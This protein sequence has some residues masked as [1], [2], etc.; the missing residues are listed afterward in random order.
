MK[1]VHLSLAFMVLLV[2]AVILSVGRAR[3]PAD[4]GAGGGAEEDWKVVHARRAGVGRE[5]LE[6][7]LAALEQAMAAKSASWSTLEAKVARGEQALAESRADLRKRIEEA[8]VEA[9]RLTHG[10]DLFAAGMDRTT[11]LFERYQELELRVNRLEGDIRWCES[12]IP[13]IREEIEATVDPD[14]KKKLED[15]LQVDVLVP[16]GE[17][18]VALEEI[19]DEW[20]TVQAARTAYYTFH[21]SRMQSWMDRMGQAE[22]RVKLLEEELADLPLALE[23]DHPEL[24]LTEA[25]AAWWKTGTSLRAQ[26]AATPAVLESS[27]ETKCVLCHFTTDEGYW[28][29]GRLA[30]SEHSRT[31]GDSTDCAG[32][33]GGDGAGTALPAA[34]AGLVPGTL[35]AAARE[36]VSGTTRLAAGEAAW[37]NHRCEACHELAGEGPRRRTGAQLDGLNG[38]ARYDWIVRWLSDPE[39]YA[40]H[41]AMPRYGLSERESQEVALFF[42]QFAHAHHHH[43]GGG[44]ASATS[45]HAVDQRPEGAAG[46][47]HADGQEHGSGPPLGATITGYDV[48]AGRSLFQSVGCLGCHALRRDSEPVGVVESLVKEERRL[49]RG[50]PP[51]RP[52]IP[53]GTV[54][55]EKVLKILKG[56]GV[57]SI[58]VFVEAPLST[59]LIDERARLAAGHPADDPVFPAGTVIDREVYDFLKADKV[60][61]VALAGRGDGF[62]PDLTFAGDKLK[63]AHLTMWIENPVIHQ[64]EA[65]MP[66][67]GLTPTESWLIATWLE[68]LHD[69]KGFVPV[70]KGIWRDLPPLAA[71]GV[72]F[73]LAAS[74]PV[75]AAGPEVTFE[76]SV[77]FEGA[78]DPMG[79]D[80]FVGLAGTIFE[81]GTVD[82]IELFPFA[83]RERNVFEFAYRFAAPGAARFRLALV[84]QPGSPP[85]VVEF[86][87][88]VAAKSASL[89]AAGQELVA[90]LSC[91]SCH[92]IP[93]VAAP[94]RRDLTAALRE[95]RARLTPEEFAAWLVERTLHHRLPGASVDSFRFDE[96]AARSVAAY[97]LDRVRSSER[98]PDTGPAA[99]LAGRAARVFDRYNCQGCHR[100]R[101]PDPGGTI[102]PDLSLAGLR[103]HPSYLERYLAAPKRVRPKGRTP[104]MPTFALTGPERE[105]LVLHLQAQGRASP[106]AVLVQEAQSAP[107]GDLRRGE[108]LVQEFRCR[109]CHLVGDQA[110][111]VNDT[112]DYSLEDLGRHRLR[113]P[114]LVDLANRLDPAWMAAWIKD[115][116]EFQPDTPMPDHE[117]TLEDAVSIRDWLLGLRS[118]AAAP[119]NED[120]KS[121]QGS[122]DR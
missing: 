85:I 88:E 104:T 4:D 113:A 65:V 102:G 72:E 1:R 14:E 106:A 84:A 40:T 61:R 55:D 57:R 46:H 7:E 43:H 78:L 48:E 36:D 74:T 87:L 105:D 110:K 50:F 101:S 96:A 62:A 59:D 6:R 70:K 52:Y 35:L 28:L 83:D 24:V 45:E 71:S 97:V 86:P 114:H 117:F 19:Q 116:H 90:R 34:H 37:A 112:T 94:P 81:G 98:R 93:D 60:G 15:S 108:A 9:A 119:K 111:Y 118:S 5:R 68:E 41:P 42:W 103:F 16:L 27:A 66:V 67:F 99:L 51:S 20:R 107:A 122:N 39:A 54:I 21:E 64:A 44:A 77:R 63:K 11:A 76:V 58:D 3:A 2:G 80:E 91:A 47:E 92:V 23:E 18:K 53:A 75:L 49:Y 73:S 100:L 82:G 33:H 12:F 10:H 121:E 79:P 109:S 56:E 25:E 29:S 32:C 120:P 31:G 8:K 115:P 17:K 38:W 22:G 26:L 89:E 30:F 13:I 95:Q 69:P